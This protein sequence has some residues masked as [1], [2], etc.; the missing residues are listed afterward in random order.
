MLKQFVSGV[1][2]TLG[3]TALACAEPSAQALH[4]QQCTGCHDSDVYTREDRKMQS[5][6]Q[7]DAQVAGCKSNVTADWNA[8]QTQSVADYLNDAYYHFPQTNAK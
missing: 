7:L 3:L 2:I 6:A 8:A 4:A 5:K 1:V